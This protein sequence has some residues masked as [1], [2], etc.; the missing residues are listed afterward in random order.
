[1]TGKVIELFRKHD[2][3]DYVVACYG[4]LHTMGALAI[5]EDIDL[6]VEGLEKRRGRCGGGAPAEGA[7]EDPR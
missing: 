2:V 5:V 3:I 4:A 7:A 1:M 6:L